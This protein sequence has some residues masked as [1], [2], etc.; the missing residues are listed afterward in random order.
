MSLRNECQII[1]NDWRTQNNNFQILLLLLSCPDKTQNNPKLFTHSPSQRQQQRWW[2]YL[3]HSLHHH[4][5]SPSVGTL[6]NVHCWVQATMSHQTAA[7]CRRISSPGNLCIDNII[8][9]WHWEVFTKQLEEKANP[10][11]LSKL[12][13][14]NFYVQTEQVPKSFKNSLTCY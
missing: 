10:R 8:I 14:C 11:L 9:I 4:T 12:V 6:S 13:R 2:L 1:V 7:A 5:L 3:Q